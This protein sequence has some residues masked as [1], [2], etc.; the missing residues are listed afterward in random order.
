QSAT[1]GCILASNAPTLDEVSLVAGA[2]GTTE[3]FVEKDWHVARI[4]AVLGG[5]DFADAEIY[6]SGG[7]ALSKA[8]GVI[9]RFSED[10]DFRCSLASIMKAKVQPS[11]RADS[12]TRMFR[13]FCM[14]PGMC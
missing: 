4:L 6:F 2:L 12:F 13:A 1:T 8:Y 7:T 3:C 9:K 11:A 14:M 10:I 5:T